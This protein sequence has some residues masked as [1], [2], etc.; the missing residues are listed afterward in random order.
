MSAAPQERARLTLPVGARDHASGPASAPLVLLEYGDYDC[1][2]CSAVYPTV[3][4]LQK[5]F[6]DD[7]RFIYRNLPLTNVHPRAQRAAETAEW[8]ALHGAFWPMH[9]YLYEHHEHL[10][11]KD[12]IAAARH[13]SLDPRGLQRAWGTHALIGRVKEDFLSGIAS[14]VSGT[15]R[16]F[17]NDRRYDGPT[18][19]A[20]LTAAL[21]AARAAVR[22][23]SG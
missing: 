10:D 6:G 16:F 18:D 19:L 5:A 3:K 8:A 2:Y 4:Q 1:P 17:I 21:E 14:G 11:D 7:L 13:F 9:D 23:R 15:P 22:Q 12:L 20:S